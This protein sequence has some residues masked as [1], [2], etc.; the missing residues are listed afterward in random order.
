MKKAVQTDRLFFSVDRL[1]LLKHDLD[2]AVLRI[3]D[4]IASRDQRGLSLIHSGTP[5]GR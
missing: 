3:A 1:L 5:L 4:V 2:L